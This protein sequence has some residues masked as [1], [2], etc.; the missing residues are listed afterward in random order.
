MRYGS[1]LLLTTITAFFAAPGDASAQYGYYRP[2]GAYGGYG[3]WGAGT[4][5][6][7]SY[8]AGMG[9]AIQAQGAYN[10]MTAAAAIDAEKARSLAIDNKL[11]ASQA[12]YELQRMNREEKAAREEREAKL[13]VTKV[14]PPRIPRLTPSQLDPVTGQITWPAVFQTPMF[15]PYRTKL[16]ALFA[17]KAKDP[18]HDVYQ[19]VRTLAFSMRDKFDTLHDTIPTT[20]F[21]AAR[22]FLESLAEAP[23]FMGYEGA[24]AAVSQ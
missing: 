4:T 22:H 17:A 2:Y 16:D 11:K 19:E 10:Q 6:A 3:G 15:E 7:G 23:R 5:V 9:Q 20:D 12:Y 21:F 8:M 1:V 18:L 14:P 24:A 13:R